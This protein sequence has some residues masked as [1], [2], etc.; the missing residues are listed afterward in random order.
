M[1]RTKHTVG[2]TKRR[3]IFE[4]SPPPRSPPPLQEIMPEPQSQPEKKKKRAYR[5]RPGTVALREI[6]KC[7]KSTDLLI[8]FAPFVRLVRD[9]ATNYAKDGKPMPWTPHALLALQ[10]AAKYDMV[11][12]FEKAIL[13]LIYA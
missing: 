13:C 6:R 4:R 3:L 10:E 12:V 8:P 7:R 1:G 11:D 5:F 9:I 2:A